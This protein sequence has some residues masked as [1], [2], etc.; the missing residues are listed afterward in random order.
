MYSFSRIDTDPLGTTPQQSFNNYTTA[1]FAH[2]NG[3][4]DKELAERAKRTFGDIPAYNKEQDSFIGRALVSNAGYTGDPFSYLRNNNKAIPENT[5][6]EYEL[7]HYIGKEFAANSQKIYAEKKAD[8]EAL[9]AKQNKAIKEGLDSL[10]AILASGRTP[11][12]QEMAA[13]TDAKLTPR[14]NILFQDVQEAVSYL[15]SIS[16]ITPQKLKEETE[17][18]KKEWYDSVHFAWTKDRTEEEHMQQAA[19]NLQEGYNLTREQ[20]NT[21][22]SL[23]KDDNGNLDPAAIALFTSTL[24]HKANKEQTIDSAFWRNVAFGISDFAKNTGDFLGRGYLDIV[25]TGGVVP[26][27]DTYYQP[28]QKEVDAARIER[29]NNYSPDIEKLRAGMLAVHDNALN[30]AEEASEIAKVLTQGGTIVGSELIPL[31]ASSVA[32]L[33]MGTAGSLLVG[34]AVNAAARFPSTASRNISEAYASG[35]KNPLAYAL[36]STPAQVGIES[37]FAAGLGLGVG[38]A[39][40]N[41]VFSAAL[42]LPGFARAAGAVQSS[43]L[44]RWATGGTAE[45]LGELFIEDPAATLTNKA[46]FE[47]INAIAGRDVFDAPEWSSV[48]KAFTAN[49]ENPTQAAAITAYSFVLGAFG[50]GI[51]IHKAH[52]FAKNRDNLL[53]SAFSQKAA[54]EISTKAEEL[55]EQLAV[56]QT[57]PELSAQAKQEQTDKLLLDFTEFQQKKLQDDVLDAKPEELIKRLRKNHFDYMEKAQAI[58]AIATGSVDAALKAQN[59]TMQTLPSGNRLLT[60]KAEETKADGS[61]ELKEKKLELSDAQFLN[62]VISH[63]NKAQQAAMADYQSAVLGNALV[64]KARTVDDIKHDLVNVRDLAAAAPAYAH[65]A[66]KGAIDYDAAVLIAKAAKATRDHLIE[67]GITLEQ[68]NTS[69]DPHTGATLESLLNLPAAFTERV[70]DATKTTEGKAAKIDKGSVQSA[71]LRLPSAKSLGDSIVLYISGNSTLA[72][73]AEELTESDLVRAINAG[74]ITLEQV[75][76]NL[77]HLQSELR[78]YDPNLSLFPSDKKIE[79][80][81][82]QNIVEAYSTLQELDILSRASRFDLSPTSKAII[83]YTLGQTDIARALRTAA[84]A[85]ATYANSEAGKEYLGSTGKTLSVLLDAAGL[86]QSKLYSDLRAEESDRIA[87]EAANG[88]PLAALDKEAQARLD[89]DAAAADKAALTNTEPDIPRTEIPAEESLTGEPIAVDPLETADNDPTTGEY[90]PSPLDETATDP[91]FISP[92]T[93]S[94][95]GITTGMMPPANLKPH[96]ALAHTPQVAAA[97]FSPQYNPNAKPILALRMPDGSNLIVAGRTRQQ[98]ALA[99]PNCQAVK[100]TLIDYDPAIHTDEWVQM[101][102]AGEHIINR[103][104]TTEHFATYFTHNPITHAQAIEQGL[105][106]IDPKTGQPTAAYIKGRQEAEQNLEATA[107]AEA[108]AAAKAAEE[109]KAKAEKQLP[110]KTKWSTPSAKAKPLSESQTKQTLISVAAHGLSKYKDYRFQFNHTLTQRKNGTEYTVATD[111]RRITV[112]SQPTYK[113]D[114]DDTTQEWHSSK[115]EKSKENQQAPKWARVIPTRFSGET[116]VDFSYYSFFAKGLK[117]P[118]KNKHIDSPLLN[119]NQLIIIPTTNGYLNLNPIYVRDAYKQ[120]VDL[121]KKFGFSPIVKLQYDDVA[122]PVMFSAEHN[123]IKWQYVLMPMHRDELEMGKAEPGD[124]ILGEQP[125]IYGEEQAASNTATLSLRA[126]PQEKLPSGLPLYEGYHI[127]QFGHGEI[128]DLNN[129]ADFISG[130]PVGIVASGTYAFSRDFISLSKIIASGYIK[131]GKTELNINGIGKVLLNQ[132]GVKDS[133]AHYGRN[134]RTSYEHKQR[135]TDAFALVP[136]VLEKGCLVEYGQ[137]VDN[138]Q[139]YSY[140]FLAPVQIGAESCVMAVRVRKTT[141][142]EAK[143][144]LHGVELLDALKTKAQGL[145]HFRDG[146]NKATSSDGTAPRDVFRLAKKALAVK[147]NNADLKR[148]PSPS[149]QETSVSSLSLRRRPDSNLASILS[150]REKTLLQVSTYIKRHANR[151]ARVIGADS[152][153]L[154]ACVHF[155][156]ANA[157]IAALDKYIFP[158]DLISRGSAEYRKLKDLRALLEEFVRIAQKGK[159]PARRQTKD[160][161]ETTKARIRALLD[162]QMKQAP[163]LLAEDGSTQPDMTAKDIRKDLITRLAKEDAAQ[164]LAV[165]MDGLGQIIETHLRNSILDKISTSLKAMRP[166]A[167]SYG[168]YKRNSLS[169][170]TQRKLD[171]TA[172]FINLK[173]SEKADIQDQLDHAW[174]IL[175]DIA[176]ALS[177][178]NPPSPQNIL[179]TLPDGIV[180]QAY[181]HLVS[182]GGE[183]TIDMLEDAIIS[184]ST[185]FQT[186]AYLNEGTFKDA[187]RAYMHLNELVTDA[188]FS[189]DAKAAAD[190]ERRNAYIEEAIAAVPQ[191]IA[192]ANYREKKK[193]NALG[194]F[195]DNLMSAGQLFYSLSGIDG[196]R[197]VAMNTMSRI[198]SASPA[199]LTAQKEIEYSLVEAY[200]RCFKPSIHANLPEDTKARQ[201][202]LSKHLNKDFNAF[203]VDMQKELDTGI[204]LEPELAPSVKAVRERQGKNAPKDFTQTLKLSKFEAL[205]II[206]TGEQPEYQ[207]NLLYH[208]YTP[209]VMS[210][211][212]EMVGDELMEFG[213]FMR[214]LLINSGVAQV[215][216]ERTGHNLPDNPY[217]WPSHIDH[218]THTKGESKPDENKFRTAGTDNFLKKR[219]VSIGEIKPIDALTVFRNNMTERL[220]YIYM[221]P[222]TDEWHSLLANPHFAHRLEGSIGKD[223]M[224][225]LRAALDVLDNAAAADAYMNGV[226]NK[227]VS[228]LH[229]ARAVSLLSGNIGTFIRQ[230]TAFNHVG[231]LTNSGL[232]SYAQT[233][234]DTFNGKTQISLSEMLRTPQF[235]A[236]YQNSKFYEELQREAENASW[237]KIKQTALNISNLGMEAIGK[238]DTWA[239]AVSACVYYNVRHKEYSS[240]YPNLTKQ[241]LHDKC[242]QDVAIMLELVAQPLLQHQKS[243]YAATTTNASIK[244]ACFMGTE[245]LNKLGMSRAAYLKAGGGFKGLL[246]YTKVLAAV[247]IPAAII[248]IMLAWLN[249][250]MPDDEV[251]KYA[252]MTSQALQGATGVSILFNLPLIGGFFSQV[253]Q[254]SYYNKDEWQNILP[255]VLNTAYH[256]SKLFK[257]C[258]GENSSWT[259]EELAKTINQ[260]SRDA[261]QLA[262]AAKTLPFLRETTS[263]ISAVM[264]AVAAASNTLRVPASVAGNVIN[265]DKRIPDS[266][267]NTRKKSYRQPVMEKFL[268]EHIFADTDY[269]KRKAAAKRERSRHTRKENAAAKR[270]A[271]QRE[272][273]KE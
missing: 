148:K 11:N 259:N 55:S 108:Q 187:L 113:G 264:G 31:A 156:Q 266:K 65:I 16:T 10:A 198:A 262:G 253:F 222:I 43:A 145:S 74:T 252:F 143:F 12:A 132:S 110:G 1:L 83:N 157:I 162:A 17:R 150:N 19:A 126:K 26:M 223:R 158:Q 263:T 171:L 5:L 245:L 213:Y 85:W 54:T 231:I 194:S 163:N 153:K 152:D 167:N 22:I 136:D 269:E 71:A 140:I 203:V 125:S 124:I 127:N 214:S 256:Y 191:Q 144:Y 151:T 101:T 98:I 227:L 20:Y 103:T 220:N 51:D 104:A 200:L 193:T 92:V 241:E 254:P 199:I 62:F 232:A 13:L 90:N 46:I 205:N 218:V 38:R 243:L 27:G 257:I 179:K 72:D 210:Q 80:I 270:K 267:N 121:G 215:Y 45:S 201:A 251:D 258:T 73:I 75:K 161:R 21:I 109:A 59:A 70:T 105:V 111:G 204:I 67:Q 32:T 47:S 180:K 6:T 255:D 29:D 48:K 119:N 247:G 95:F 106:P 239:N 137:Q 217:Y 37:A 66:A 52:E 96:P 240:Q 94:P 237:N 168:R 170:D 169:A 88:F 164:V 63:F 154:R 129:L 118:A 155:A 78:N 244:A 182:R 135:V 117:G 268:S 229:S 81:T 224:K 246:A 87:T 176:A 134:N 183:V 190:R 178:P 235:Q 173:E 234:I 24:N 141:G 49:I 177:A 209:E 41:A 68:A 260:C 248:N 196:F 181:E 99:D 3:A 86:Q 216:A 44:L 4:A 228:S 238:V 211:L 249:D 114:T 212:R 138:P 225:K 189:W 9:L 91:A 100:V 69:A 56:I 185:T 112:I 226:F 34:G 166:K 174:S 142:Q 230:A 97:D 146:S 7:Y 82:F 107:K 25:A 242:M 57:N 122:S 115:G 60:Y 236:R 40:S 79:D 35:K 42:N 139:L 15:Q 208:G 273:Q 53:A 147:Q 188:R 18:V 8:A 221:R 23:L 165:M 261:A 159:L 50:F 30:P 219:V 184:I 28:T 77:L 120:I 116:S 33:G 207:K 131:S 61:T 202:I 64:R 93:K 133:I 39:A 172:R 58:H 76:E 192:T 206:L 84:D 89:K 272:Q 130:N 233:V 175:S 2:V 265:S 271:K 128:S 250:E 160:G 197:S 195:F 186:F 14:F 123:G 36:I 149:Q 102:N